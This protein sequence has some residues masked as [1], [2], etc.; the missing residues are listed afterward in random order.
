MKSLI[1]ETNSA[2]FILLK[3]NIEDVLSNLT[4]IKN[5]HQSLNINIYK[6]NG[7][8]ASEIRE[9]CLAIDIVR[10]GLNRKI[11]F[12]ERY[13]T[14][15]SPY[16]A[17][18]IRFDSSAKRSLFFDMRY[19]E[20][21]LDHLLLTDNSLCRLGGLIEIAK[22]AIKQINSIHDSYQIINDLDSSFNTENILDTNI[23]LCKE[24][25]NDSC[26]ANFGIG[27]L[28][29]LESTFKEWHKESQ[30]NSEI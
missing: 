19:S 17:T 23:R 27:A 18:A 4:L 21:I 15:A 2:T 7:H 10:G 11:N 14:P 30:W 16:I 5:S 12:S 9:L 25:I 22:D 8:F 6:S 3:D 28:N 24:K 26:F 29:Y 1:G 13:N 20:M